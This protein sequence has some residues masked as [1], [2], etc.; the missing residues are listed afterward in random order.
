VQR[1]HDLGFSGWYLLL[2]FVPIANLVFMIMR[3]LAASVK[4]MNGYDVPVNYAS[5]IKGSL[6]P[7][8][9]CLELD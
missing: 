6:Y 1:L 9:N 3:L 8:V 4:D 5:F 2:D 7:R